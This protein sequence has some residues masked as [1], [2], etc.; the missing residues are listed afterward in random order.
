MIVIKRSGEEVV[1]DSSKIE[2]AVRK[3]NNA[4]TETE[5]M[6]EMTLRRITDTVVKQCME[7]NRAVFV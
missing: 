7:Y 1:F 3:A 6:D 4:T 5:Q 2:N